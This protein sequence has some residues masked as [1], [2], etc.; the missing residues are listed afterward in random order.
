MYMQK[1]E[2]MVIGNVRSAKQVRDM[3]GVD[4]KKMEIFK[5]L[6]LRLA[7][8]AVDGKWKWRRV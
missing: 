7:E 2:L 8:L 6:C 4:I 1:L 3:R 5:Y